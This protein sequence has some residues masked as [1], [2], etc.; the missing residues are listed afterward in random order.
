MEVIPA[1]LAK[2]RE[3]LNNKLEKVLLLTKKVQID[4]M[5]GKFVPNQTI[6]LD[7]ITFN[8]NI[9]YEIHLMVSDPLEYIKKYP[10]FFYII[11]IETIKNKEEFEKIKAI[12]NKNFAL[13]INPSTNVEELF[14][15]L[16]EVNEVLVMSVNPGF[17]GQRYI[18]DIE[19]KIKILREKFPNLT[20]GVD[21]G[22]NEYTAFRAASAGANKLI[23]ASAIFLSHNIREAISKLEESGKRGKK[24][25]EKIEDMR[26]ISK[27]IRKEIVKMI[28]EAKSGHPAGSLGVVEIL[29]SLYFFTLNHNPQDPFWEDR[30][31]FI[32]SNGHVCPALYATLAY[33]GYFS[34]DLL[35][36]LRK[37]NSPLQGHPH[38]GSLPG[39][40]TSSGPL[41]QGLSQAAGMALVSKREKKNWRVYCLMSDGEQQEGQTWEAV[42]FA[43]KYKLNNLTA[44][45]DRNFI[46]ID[47]YTEDVMPLEP[48]KDKYLAFNWNVIEVNG[49]DFE[50]LINAFE[51]SKISD[52]PTVIIANTIAGKGVDFMEN[53]FEWHGKPLTK[54]DLEKAIH[55]LEK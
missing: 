52:K 15:Y 7:S 16:K 36:S 44:I 9:K 17:S 3:E 34:K 19:E 39:I 23:A 41:G 13:A 6:S 51:K 28:A 1:I 40:E 46:Q 11:H 37:L 49:H 14:P 38:R 43:A 47:G 25:R 55:S 42:M 30:D 20:I 31:R 5:D 10:H 53:K 27:E 26:K 18:E 29:V 33:A 32:L 21:G 54:E 12:T 22:I 35:K 24:M 45:V 48:L 4:I 2:T 50:E 8:P